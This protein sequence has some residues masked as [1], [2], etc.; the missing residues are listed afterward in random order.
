[1]AN[2]LFDLINLVV[3]VYLV[4]NF[5]VVLYNFFLNLLGN[6]FLN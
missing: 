2:Y 1:M 6:L 5:K 4:E 3:V